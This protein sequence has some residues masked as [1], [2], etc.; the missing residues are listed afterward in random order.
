[1][2][3]SA[4]IWDIFWRM[5]AL[6]AGYGAVLGCVYG[7]LYVVFTVF[8]SLSAATDFGQVLNGAVIFAQFG[9]LFGLFIGCIWGLLVGLIAGLLVIVITAVA[10]PRFVATNQYRLI[11]QLVC[12]GIVVLSLPVIA[13]L[14]IGPYPITQS[15]LIGILIPGLLACWAFWHIGSSVAKWVQSRNSLSITGEDG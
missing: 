7:I 4:L 3:R 6:G 9:L 8:L 2:K 1:M 12:L 10:P 15:A 5:A 11:V 13:N 14:M